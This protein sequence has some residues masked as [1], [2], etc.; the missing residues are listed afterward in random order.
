MDCAYGMPKNHNGRVRLVAGNNLFPLTY[1]C[2][3]IASIA[4]VYL[5][6]YLFYV[7]HFPPLPPPFLPA[8][9][10]IQFCDFFYVVV[11]PLHSHSYSHPSR[12]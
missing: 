9:L 10:Y 2:I 1:I 4:K 5:S 8:H 3:Y 7:D 11:S 6:I 12:H